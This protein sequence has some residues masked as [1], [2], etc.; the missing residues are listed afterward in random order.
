MKRRELREIVLQSL[1]QID[2]SDA[3]VE[4][5][6]AYLQEEKEL[7]NKDLAFIGGKVNGTL[8]H[9]EEVDKQISKYLKD[10][11]FE[12]IPNVDRAIL[13]MSVYEMLFERETSYK[14]V[15]NEAI[16]MAKEFSTVESGKF[17]NGVL[18]SFV[19]DNLKG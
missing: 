1:F 4:D 6:F 15:L 19:K 14:I 18:G 17:V 10:W 7:D 8:A 5:V 16:E 11:T 3:E 2:F 9:L 12:R 13:R